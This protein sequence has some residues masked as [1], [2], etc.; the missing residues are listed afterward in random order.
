MSSKKTKL[1]ESAQKN[2]LKGLYDRAVDEYRQIIQLDPIDT[3]HRQRL[4][5]ILAKA[6]QK[7]D[8]VK[9]YTF[10]AKHYID[11]VHYLKA[12]AVYKQIQKLDPTNP[13]ISLTLA[14]LNEKQGLIGNA[15][16]EYTAAVHIYEKNGENLKALKTLLSMMALDPSNSAVRLRI[17]EKYFTTGSEE[18]SLNEFE[19]LLRDLQGRN[20]ENGFRLITEKAVN[21]L[22]DRAEELIGK[23]S[24]EQT[25][26]DLTPEVSQPSHS[27][28]KIIPTET[29]HNDQTVAVTLPDFS[30]ETSLP[31][32]VPDLILYDDIEPIDDILPLEDIDNLPEVFETIEKEDEWEEEI[33]LAALS[34]E[35][36]FAEEQLSTIYVA[37][38]FDTV[39]DLDEMD[40]ELEIDEYDDVESSSGSAAPINSQSFRTDESFDLGN[41]LS[42]FA[43]E[44]DFELFSEAGTNTPF[45]FAA[46]SGFKK[47][48]LDNEDAESHYSLGLAYKEMGLFD[49]AIAEFIVAS[50]SIER[51]VDSLILQGVCLREIGDINKAVEILS[52]ILQN[53]SITDDEYLGLQYELAL[54]HEA[55]GELKKAKQLFT[56][57]NRAR[58]AFSDVVTRLKNLQD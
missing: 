56:D 16:A 41:E 21:L 44:L 26:D 14:S 42:F 20:D 15:T 5:E 52:D 51:R 23:I 17:A 57:I 29:L 22:G 32:G 12:I 55:S 46:D 40:L 45:D 34:P 4:A 48:E 31:A 1:L 50:R 6:N 47:S 11:S 18:K 25:D 58:P 38:A 19:L 33:D 9:E 7:D 27:E 10:L 54:C 3:R 36:P 37:E 28:D 49:E 53:K 8:A 24:A 2:F 35:N 39:M 43:D 13:E 30:F